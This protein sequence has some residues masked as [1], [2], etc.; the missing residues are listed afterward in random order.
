MNLEL[1]YKRTDDMKVA[2]NDA[3]LTVNY[4]EYAVEGAYKAGLSNS[5]R[6]I[7]SRIQRKLDAA[8]ESN[9]KE[10]ELEAAE[11]DFLR[12]AFKTA[13]FPSAA[14]KYVVV[15]EEEIDKL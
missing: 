2:V 13:T 7:Y 4:I 9:T 5:Q 11:K 12:D 15:L 3:S 6:R 1:D 10:V 14:A 8:I